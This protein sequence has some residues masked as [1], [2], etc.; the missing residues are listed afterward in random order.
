MNFD[1]LLF[2]RICAELQ[3]SAALQHAE[4]HV[5]VKDSVVTISGR[6]YSLAQ[7][8][9]AEKAVRR[10]PDVRDLIID[11][12]AAAVPIRLEDRPHYSNED[13]DWRNPEK[14]GTSS[15]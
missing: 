4:I 13:Y 2:R 9:A 11:I 3:A 14:F 6:V 8:R 5:H 12:R 10:V 15:F 7:R 1:G